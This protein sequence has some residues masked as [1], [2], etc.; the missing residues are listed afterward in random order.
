MYGEGESS[1]GRDGRLVGAGQWWPG[2]RG[3]PR[4]ATEC[5][6]ACVQG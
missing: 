4:S 2:L 6:A 3:P 1:Q 5:S